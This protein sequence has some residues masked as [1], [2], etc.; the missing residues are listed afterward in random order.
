VCL[1]FLLETLTNM[2]SILQKENEN[3]WNILVLF[4]FSLSR[5]RQTHMLLCLRQQHLILPLS[6]SCA[7]SYCTGKFCTIDHFYAILL[8]WILAP[9]ECCLCNKMARNCGAAIW[10]CCILK[11]GDTLCFPSDNSKESRAQ[12]SIKLVPPPIKLVEPTSCYIGRVCFCFSQN[13]ET[14]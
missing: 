11:S 12:K 2:F 9:A 14:W 4:Y 5:E 13:L 6:V 8:R 3:S 10:Y 1:F 7:G